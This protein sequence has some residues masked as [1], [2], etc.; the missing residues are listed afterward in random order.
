MEKQEFTEKIAKWLK[1]FLSEKFTETHD[2]LEVIVPDSNLSKIQNGSIKLCQGYS[3][4]EFKPDIFAILK[5]KKTDEIELILANRSTGSISLKEIGELY[6]YSRLADS[7]MSLLFSINGVSN[8]VGIL[9]LD[10][11]IKK[12]LLNYGDGKEI[13]ILSWDK[14]KDDIKYNSVIPFEKKSL[15]LS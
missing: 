9:L 5:N 13:I 10:E 12:R 14:N 4:W 11:S 3:A 1:S 6:C 7:K 2:I 15:F 8:E